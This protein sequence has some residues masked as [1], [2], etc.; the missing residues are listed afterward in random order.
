MKKFHQG[1]AVSDVDQWKNIVMEEKSTEKIPDYLWMLSFALDQGFIERNHILLMQLEFTVKRAFGLN[2]KTPEE[3]AEFFASLKFIGGESACR[4]VRGDKVPPTELKEAKSFNDQ[5]KLRFS[6][7][8]LGGPLPK[9]EHRVLA[10]GTHEI[11]IQSLIADCVENAAPL[12]KDD[13]LSN[14][15]VCIAF[16]GMSVEKALTYCRRIQEPVGLVPPLPIEFM[17]DTSKSVEEVINEILINHKFVNGIIEFSAE[18]LDGT[19]TN[20]V[21]FYPSTGEMTSNDVL[22]MVMEVVRKTS[23]CF[24]CLE[25]G[26]KCDIY[27]QGNNENKKYIFHC[28]W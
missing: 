24:H 22:N 27:C 19:A 23:C 8:N 10:P 5:V 28:F 12:Y 18:S 20:H 26:N 9:T 16:D 4:L 14:Y 11:M 6:R 3:L 13:K 25:E 15:G 2:I 21:A 1:E 17:K 7:T